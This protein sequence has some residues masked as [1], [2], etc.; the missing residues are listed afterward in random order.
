MRNPYDGISEELEQG[1]YLLFEAQ[2]D[3]S[4]G[5]LTDAR[6]KLLRAQSTLVKCNDSRAVTFLAQIESLLKELENS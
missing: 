6:T 2:A 5:R 4:L 3:K 1:T